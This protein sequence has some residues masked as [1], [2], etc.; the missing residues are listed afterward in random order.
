MRLTRGTRAVLALTIGASL[1]VGCADDQED[2]VE[3]TDETRLQTA[4]G[5]SDPTAYC[6]LSQE[7][8]AATG[9]PTVEQLGE[10]ENVAPPEIRDAVVTIIEA[11]GNEDADAAEIQEA[12]AEIVAW[13]AENCDQPEAS[14]PDEN[15][16]PGQLGG[17]EPPEESEE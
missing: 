1:L 13:E 15:D 6:L 17:V 10:I 3:E 7:L 9:R 4:A 2:A 16:A 11:I 5:T 12:E 14:A 8:S